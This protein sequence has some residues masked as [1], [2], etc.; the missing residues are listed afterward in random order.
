[1]NSDFVNIKQILKQSKFNLSDLKMQQFLKYAEL[2]IEWNKK[3]NLT[4]ITEPKDIVIKHF[5]DSLLALDVYDIPQN[6]TVIDI[7]TGAGFPGMPIKIVRPD[8]KM[9]L[10]DSLNKRVKFLEVLKNCLNIN[11]NLIHARAEEA[12]KIIGF[13]ESF[14]VVMS[15]A[16]APMNILLEYCMPFVK[17]DG[18]FVSLKGKNVELELKNAANAMFLLNAEILKIRSFSLITQNDRSIVIFKK[19]SKNIDIYPRNSS[20]ILKKPL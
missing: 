7:G 6:A 11:V 9:T 12:A 2:L 8:I 13:R 4:A 3:I 14:D 10:L 15:R 1:M 19:T 20:K 5:F 18:V 17:I 16:V